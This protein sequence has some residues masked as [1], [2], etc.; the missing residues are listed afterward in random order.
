M[1]INPSNSHVFSDEQLLAMAKELG[2][3][4]PKTPV[5]DNRVKISVEQFRSMEKLGTGFVKRGHN[6][7]KVEKEGEEYFLKRMEEETA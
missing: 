2:I 7:W 1:T 3:E 4:I 6:V 5:P